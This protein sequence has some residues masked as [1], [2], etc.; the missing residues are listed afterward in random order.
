MR[1]KFLFVVILAF[2]TTFA[3][4]TF[5]QTKT[6]E[7]AST[8]IASAIFSPDNSILA[9]GVANG[10]YLYDSYSLIEITFIETIA[11]I[12]ISSF[13]P[14]GN[15]LA[16]GSKDNT[17][18]IW[19]VKNRI[20]L[21]T[22]TGHNGRISFAGFS[23]DG[24]LLASGS[25]DGLL[26][27]WDAKTRL[28]VA[29]LQGHTSK[30]TAI[31]FSQNGKFLISGS[32]DSMLKLWDPKT[33]QELA[34]LRGKLDWSLSPNF[35]PD[36]TLVPKRQ[37]FRETLRLSDI[38]VS[39]PSLVAGD[40]TSIEA[41]SIYS[42]DE[43]ALSHV[44]KAN[45]GLIQGTGNK[46][47]YVAPE[48]AGTYSVNVRA[49]DGAISSERTT[50]VNVEQGASKSSVLLGSNTYWSA[51]VL[52]DKISYSINVSRIPS[53]KVLLHF[54]ITQ[55]KD[56]FD[57]FLSVEVGQ[58]VILQDMAIGNEQPSTGIRTIRD[59][60]VTDIIN[61]PGQYKVTFYIR[62]GDRASNGWLM[63]EAKLIG[64]EGS[65]E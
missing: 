32:A 63:N 52:K 4:Y 6:S 64:V 11:P 29:T 15:L 2:C 24:N 27:L 44:W 37:A 33:Y 28:G 1:I 25:E 40:T 46:A 14:D 21:A 20:E 13:S 45:A 18:V 5:A 43:T 12:T 3:T 61:K 49:T 22:L 48:E 41:L 62:P 9:V 57:A 60:D 50:E 23:P 35:M 10:V 38:R 34:T 30:I 47:T 51:K 31:N 54:D 55:D 36:M 7:L 65:I 39:A 26:K 53:T 19:D 42:G 17:L 8:N 59:I 58:K 56:K 16:T